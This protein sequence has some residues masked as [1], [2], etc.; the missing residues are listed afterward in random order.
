[1]SPVG[2]VHPHAGGVG[3]VSDMSEKYRSNRDI[4]LNCSGMSE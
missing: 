2:D 4:G 3:D 1:M